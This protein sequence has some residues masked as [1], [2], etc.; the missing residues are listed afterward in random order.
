MCACQVT[1]VVGTLRP[2]GPQPARLLCPQE[3][4]G[5]TIGMGCHALLQGIFP[6]QG[7]NPRLLSLLH[8]QVCSL[9][10]LPPG[11][12]YI[13]IFFLLFFSIIVYYRILCCTVG[14]HCLSVLYITVC[15]RQSQIPNLFVPQTLSPLVAISLCSMPVRLL[16]F[17]K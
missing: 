9:P 8:W 15:I 4:P 10:L 17:C 3:S 5:E 13:Y 11:K 16:L 6:T 1:S 7:S 2:R 12:P 14:P